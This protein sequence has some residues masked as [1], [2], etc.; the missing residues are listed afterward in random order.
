MS[1]QDSE[2]INWGPIRTINDDRTKPGFVT[3]WHEHVGLDIINYMIDGQCRHVDNIGNDNVA[4]I[5]QI[6]HFWCGKS[7]WHELSNVGQQDSRYLQIWIEPNQLVEDQTPSYQLI[8]RAPG[9]APLP[10]S[11]KN[12]KLQI[13]AGELDQNLETNNFSYLLVLTGSCLINGTL[14]NAG[15]A[16]DIDQISLVQPIGVPHLILFELN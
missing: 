13:W 11:F 8:D 6:Q 5:G 1:Y 3:A 2:Y 7:I 12:T 10:I 15:D 4:T 14:L 16:V 9:F